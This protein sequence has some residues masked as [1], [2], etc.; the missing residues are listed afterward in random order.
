[1]IDA[2]VLFKDFVKPILSLIVQSKGM[3]KDSSMH[4]TRRLP[5]AMS[6]VQFIAKITNRLR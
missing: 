6:S 4:T 2:K 3:Q 1:M 5:N